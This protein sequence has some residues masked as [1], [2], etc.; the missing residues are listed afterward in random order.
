[1]PSADPDEERERLRA[2]VKV[3][4][5]N[6]RAAKKESDVAMARLYS[7]GSMIDSYEKSIAILESQIDALGAE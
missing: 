1:V 3:F 4:R 7:I 6:I 2:E 5:A